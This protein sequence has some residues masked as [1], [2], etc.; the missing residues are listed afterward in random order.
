MVEAQANMSWKLWSLSAVSWTTQWLQ[1]QYGPPLSKRVAYN[2]LPCPHL[3]NRL[4]TLSPLPTDSRCYLYLLSLLGSSLVHLHCY[5]SIIRQEKIIHKNIAIRETASTLKESWELM[6]AVGIFLCPRL[7]RSVGLFC[8][9]CWIVHLVVP[10]FEIKC[11]L[12]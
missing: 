9:S 10:N 5:L 11:T 1:D 4:K 3:S 12:I 7:S 8:C 2:C 6:I